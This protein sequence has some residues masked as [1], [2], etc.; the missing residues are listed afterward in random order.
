MRRFFLYLLA[1]FILTSCDN[2]KKKDAK[3][4]S[5]DEEVTTKKKKKK[6]LEE[7]E[8]TDD[9]ETPKKKKTINQDE[10]EYKPLTKKNPSE[11]ENDYSKKTTDYTSG[12]STTD[13]RTFMNQCTNTAT[14]NVGTQRAKAYCSCMM[15]KIEKEFPVYTDINGMTKEQ[16]NAWAKDCN[17]Q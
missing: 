14:P 3:S 1:G 2:L 9:E 10:E 13:E 16:L 4:D 12:W 5:D 7:D 11:D 15:G 17:Q 8:S 6:A